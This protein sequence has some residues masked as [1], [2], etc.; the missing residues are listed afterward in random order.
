[1]GLASENR[2]TALACQRTSNAQ[3]R[4]QCTETL[5]SLWETSIQSRLR[6]LDA[7]SRPD[8]ST[9]SAVTEAELKIPRVSSA[10]SLQAAGSRC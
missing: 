8:A 9:L 1:M 2:N 6:S 4:T 3:S 5:R 10:N 7:I